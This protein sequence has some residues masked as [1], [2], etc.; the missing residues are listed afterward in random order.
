MKIKIKTISM[1]YLVYIC[2]DQDNAEKLKDRQERAA[3]A[4]YLT[5][6]HLTSSV[7][8]YMILKDTIILPWYL[9]GSGSL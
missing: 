8:G 9:G 5:L 1:V 2:K 7:V 6:K 4:L 3:H